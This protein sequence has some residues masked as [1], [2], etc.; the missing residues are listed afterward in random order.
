MI[1]RSGSSPSATEA[2]LEVL[3]RPARTV[4]GLGALLA[5]SFAL[6][7]L[8]AGLGWLVGCTSPSECRLASDCPAQQFCVQG[9]CVAECREDRDC[10]TGEACRAGRCRPREATERLCASALEC[11]VGETCAAGLCTPVRFVGSDPGTPDA[12]VP[13]AGGGLLPYG[14]VCER[15]SACESGLCLAPTGSSS[16][17]CTRAC[18]GDGECQY[19]DRCLD[20][21]GA[22]RLCGQASAGL[23]SGA[24]CPNGPEACATGLCVDVPGG[25]G[26]V[27]TQQCSPLPA[28]PPNLTCQPVSDGTDTSVPVCVPGEGGGFGQGCAA[29]ADCATGLCV[30]VGGGGICT[31]TCDTIP[32]PRGYACTAAQGPA[33]GSFQICAPE[34]ALGGR[35]GDACT[36]ASTCA[37]GLCLF[38]ARTGGA[39]CTETCLSDADCRAVPGLACVLVDG[40][41]AVC[42]PAR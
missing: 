2:G 31:S 7:L 34:G 26:P 21:P 22:G 29:A 28:C 6:A 12:G 19:P 14:A 15:A 4:S 3:D 5:R 8:V 33:G 11:D 37:S 40:S 32:C 42:G 27:C 18:A 23:P 24:P 1:R 13:D 17:R 41:V 38:D 35:F 36:G 16:G 39:F 9:L 30:E 10:A 25:S 20:V